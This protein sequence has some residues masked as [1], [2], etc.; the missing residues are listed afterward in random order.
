[1]LRLSPPWEKSN[2]AVVFSNSQGG[3]LREEVPTLLYWGGPGGF[4]LENRLEIP[5]RS[6]YETTCADF[7][8]D[9]FPDLV[10]L[11][12]MHGGQRAELDPWAGV[13]IFRGGANGFDPAGR[14]AI[15]PEISLGTSNTADLDKDGYL[16]LVLGQFANGGRPTELIIYY[17][18]DKG[19]E[20]RKRRAVPSPGRSISSLIADFNDDGWLDIAVSSYEKDC[21]RI[22]WGGGAGFAENRQTVIDVPGVIDLETADLNADARL[23]LIACSYMD[24]VTGHHDTGAL[25]LWGG[26]DGFSQW[27]AQRLPAITP[28]APVVADLDGDGWLDIFFPDYHDELHREQIPSY[29][30]LGRAGGL[31]AA[32]PDGPRQRLGRGR[33]GRRFR[34]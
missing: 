30:I 32:P 29:P 21:V 24:P 4:D 6:G 1:M 12:S 5:L 26:R 27:N 11:D 13:N 23:D 25:I 31:F 22:F 14:R 34:R 10:A 7:D 28:L 33:A 17:G 20:T 8:V 18:S 15:L 19:F 9:G 16:D 2:A 3:S